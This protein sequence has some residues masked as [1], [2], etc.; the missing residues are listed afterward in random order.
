MHTYQCNRKNAVESL[1]PRR[2][3]ISPT[4]RSA[5]PYC[6]ETAA[7]SKKC[8]G[9]PLLACR[10]GLSFAAQLCCGDGD[11]RLRVNAARSSVRSTSA[12]RQIDAD[13]VWIK[14]Y[15]TM[16]ASAVL[17]VV[18]LFKIIS[19]RTAVA[20][21]LKSMLQHQCAKLLAFVTQ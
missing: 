19:K 11:R 14:V 1:R 5:M 16:H 10:M 20:E 4:A 8:L 21:V 3:I 13:F 7:S 15:R 6:T 12:D 9:R 17:G 18:I 2:S